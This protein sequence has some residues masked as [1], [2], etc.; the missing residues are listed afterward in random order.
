MKPSNFI[1]VHALYDGCI[2]AI[3]AD[4]IDSVMENSEQNVEGAMKPAC[5]SIIYSGGRCLDVTES[6]E[7]IMNMIWNAEL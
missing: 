6:Y 3:R 5:R 7:E 1:E 2:A 4:V